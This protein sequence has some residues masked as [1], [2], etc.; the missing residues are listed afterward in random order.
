[1]IHYF[2][3]Y[4]DDQYYYAFIEYHPTDL[5][6]FCAE[7]TYVD[8]DEIRDLFKQIADSIQ[9]CHEKNIAHGDIKL[10]NILIS[11]EKKPILIDFGFSTSIVNQPRPRICGSTM[12]RAPEIV[13][14]RPYYSKP[15]D[16]YALGVVLFCL[17]FDRFPFNETVTDDI[18]YLSE[19]AKLSNV[20]LSH[21]SPECTKLIIKMLL[22]EPALRP[23]ISQVLT[24]PWIQGK[25]M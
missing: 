16:I 1:M 22:K 4:E 8:E 12:Y 24:H 19:N 25:S 13:R 11:E 17:L 6:N 7:R 10:E 9:A 14:K 2:D 23:T 20:E 15:A 5:Y 21:V 18:G 3:Q